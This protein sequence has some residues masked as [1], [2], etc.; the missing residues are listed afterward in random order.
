[1]PAELLRT[2]L[3][4]TA[5][6]ERIRRREVRRSWR[7]LISAHPEARDVVGTVR[8]IA[9][10][11]PTFCAPIGLL[12]V[13]LG[14]ADEVADGDTDVAT[15]VV[16]LSV[17]GALM[18]F[19]WVFCAWAWFR[20]RRRRPLPR[21]HHRLARFAAA[22]GMSYSPG[23]TGT[24]RDAPFRRRGSLNLY[25]VLRTPG[26]RGL[27]FA[28]YEI[29]RATSANTAPAFG[30]YCALRLP[31]ALP[32]ILLRSEDGPKRP[33]QTSAELRESQVLSLEGDF[34]RYFR[35]YCPAGYER[36][37]LYLFTPDVMGRL[38]DNLRGLDIEIVDDWMYLL[39]A[40]DL[41]T[42]QPERWQALAGAVD[43]L[44]DRIER[45]ARWRDERSAPSRGGGKPHDDHTPTVAAPGRRL[46]TVWSAGTILTV[47]FVGLCFVALV[48]AINLGR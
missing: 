6:T 38:V 10:A 3:D 18:A 29:A 19:S 33:L 37:A 15:A 44:D 16:V 28:N 30:G 43:A 14:I 8:R 27:E 22:N 42:D 24:S 5:L 36:D 31:T 47:G 35:L 32:N 21:V 12:A 39:S 23:P 25:R 46:R 4:T 26:E 45:W 1:M 13:G 9:L 2:P 48:V 20:L 11:V 7:E 34:D 41:I 40:R 17:M